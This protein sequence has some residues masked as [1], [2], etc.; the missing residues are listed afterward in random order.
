MDWTAL[1]QEHRACLVN[2]VVVVLVQVAVGGLAIH[3]GGQEALQGGLQA[4]LVAMDELLR[5]PARQRSHHLQIRHHTAA[6]TCHAFGALVRS[7][8]LVLLGSQQAAEDDVQQPLWHLVALLQQRP[9]QLRWRAQPRVWCR[10]SGQAAQQAWR[11][12]EMQEGECTGK[13]RSPGA[14][15]LRWQPCCPR[16]PAQSSGIGNCCC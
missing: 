11:S 16:C 3:D 5:Q 15:A 8:L 10:L 14:W 6:L 7:R 13:Q 12:T 1:C 2:E 4:R 9:E